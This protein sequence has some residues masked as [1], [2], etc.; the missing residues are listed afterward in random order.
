MELHGPGVVWLEHG[1]GRVSVEEQADGRRL[2][3]AHPNPGVYVSRP[4]WSTA[5]PMP[6]IEKILRSKGPSYLCDE[7]ARDEDP[8]YVELFLRYSMLGYVSPERFRGARLLDFGSGS[9][10]STVNLAR[11]LPETEIVGVELEPELIAT[12]RMR[13][14]FYGLSNLVFLESP[15]GAELPPGLGTFRFINFGAVYEHL[16][17]EE[18][19][20]LPAQLWAHLDVGGVVFVN[21][22]P[23]R[24]YPMEDHTTGLPLINYLPARWAYAAARRFSARIEPGTT[25]EDLLRAGIRG[26]TAREVGRDLLRGGGEARL[27]EPTLLGLRSHADLW[28]AYSTRHQQRYLG[29][30]R[31]MRAAFDALSRIGAGPVAPGLSLAYEKLA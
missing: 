26:G 29:A 23:Y 20:R 22:L 16:L 1:D 19:R 2:V 8:D 10:G 25:D 24:F 9:G 30:K 15:S 11:M 13:A 18:R 28:Y 17:P 12:A 3:T 31:A 6:L 4:E 5:Y 7:I 14:E 21:Q 27:L